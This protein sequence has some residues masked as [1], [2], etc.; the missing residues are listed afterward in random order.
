MDM[1]ADLPPRG[2]RQA[3]RDGARLLP[4]GGRLRDYVQALRPHQW[5]KNLLVFVPLVAAHE[6][7]ARPYLAAAATFAALCACASA[8]YVL[9]DLLD[10]PHDRRHPRKRH[11]ALAAGRV[12][13]P[14]MVGT[15][16][17]LAA[18]GVVLG[19][20]VAPGAGF[21]MLGYTLTSAAYTLYLKRMLFLDVMALASLYAIR[22]VVGAA[23]AAVLLSPWLG[24]FSLLIFVALAVVKRQRELFP[25]GEY[26]APAPSGRAYRAEDR[27]VLTSLAAASGLAAVVVL[28][29]YIQSPAINSRYDQPYLLWLTCPLLVYWL[30]R[31][32]LLANR[33]AVDDDPVAFALR[34]RASWLTLVGILAAFAAAL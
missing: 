12:R 30:G 22:V 24:A 33:G 16:A 14:P 10:L 23:A 26:A 8:G 29:L 18:A 7:G 20:V 1:D 31:M 2:T 11:R 9:N 6:T 27:T 3:R 21:G 19:F 4:G 34:D 32:L 13:L 5:I 15:A 25:S 17:A 28:T